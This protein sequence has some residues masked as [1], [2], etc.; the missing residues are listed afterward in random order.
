MKIYVAGPLFTDAERVYNITVAEKLRAEGYD[1]FLPQELPINFKDK[2]WQLNTFMSNVGEIDNADVMVAIL[3]GPMC[4]DGT[5]WEVG[6]AYGQCFS[7]YGLRSDFRTAGPEGQVNWMLG[8][9]VVGIYKT[10]EDIIEALKNGSLAD[11]VKALV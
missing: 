4:D 11:G 2:K 1:V 10:V 8:E 3:D 6:Y 5:S 9:S 7:I